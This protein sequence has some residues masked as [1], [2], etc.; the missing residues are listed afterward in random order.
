[1]KYRPEGNRKVDEDDFRFVVPA[2]AR[3]SFIPP[4]GRTTN[5]LRLSTMQFPGKRFFAAFLSRSHRFGL[6]LAESPSGRARKRPVFDLVGQV[7]SDKLATGNKGKTD[8]IPEKR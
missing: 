8:R 1:M 4:K 5:D 7:I 3:S 6:V 2:L